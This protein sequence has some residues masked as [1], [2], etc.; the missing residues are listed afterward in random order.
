MHLSKNY[1]VIIYIEASLELHNPPTN[2]NIT[3]PTYNTITDDHCKKP[4]EE[5]NN[6]YA[7]VIIPTTNVKMT[8]NP[9]YAVP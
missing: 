3:N 1:V 7:E 6:C 4:V 8:P 2:K 9:A 5:P